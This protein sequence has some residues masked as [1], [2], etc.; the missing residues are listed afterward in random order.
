MTAST[1]ARAANNRTRALIVDFAEDQLEQF[2]ERSAG[3]SLRQ[4]MD[5]EIHTGEILGWPTRILAALVSLL[6]P[7]LAVTGSAIGWNRRRKKPPIP[8]RVRSA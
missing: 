6:L 5:R 7:V 1:R 4:V 8:M 2:V 3:V